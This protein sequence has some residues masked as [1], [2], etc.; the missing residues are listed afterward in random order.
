MAQFEIERQKKA[1]SEVGETR[2]ELHRM[3][4]KV[5]SNDHPLSMN[6]VILPELSETKIHQK[7]VAETAVSVA[8]L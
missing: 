4:L 2:I 5:P 7:A 8:T 6:S 3:V 1:F